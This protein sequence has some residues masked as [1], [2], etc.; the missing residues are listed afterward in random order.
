M[1]QNNGVITGSGTS[2]FKSSILEKS[3]VSLRISAP[4]NKIENK[5]GEE[6]EVKV[7]EIVEVKE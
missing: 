1:K 7:D 4:I 5:E 2:S 6:E 3:V